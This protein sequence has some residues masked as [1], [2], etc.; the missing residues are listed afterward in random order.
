MKR[1]FKIQAALL[2]LLLVAAAGCQR[3]KIGFEPSNPDSGAQVGYFSFANSAL[4]VDWNGE[5][6]N[7]DATTRAEQNVDNYTVE[8]CK[9]DG[10]E[11]VTSF[12]YGERSQKPYELEFGNYYLN[13][14]SGNSREVPDVAWNDDAAYAAKTETFE[15]TS[16][17]TE[18]SPYTFEGK[19]ITC[20]LQSTKVTVS[21]EY[22]MFSKCRDVEIN[23]TMGESKEAADFT[24]KVGTVTL[25]KNEYTGKMELVRQNT[26]SQRAYLR[27]DDPTGEQTESLT[28]S[29]SA[30]YDANGDG[31]TS[32]L[33]Y[34]HPITDNPKAGE[35]RNVI[36]YIKESDKEHTGSI[37]IETIIETWVYD[38]IVDVD[39][40][41]KSVTLSESSI[42]D[43]NHKDAPRIESAGFNFYGE[44][45]F[46]PN[47]YQNDQFKG[48]AD[49]TVDAVL[50]PKNFVV[51]LSTGNATFGELLTNNNINNA[52]VDMLEGVQT[53]G[54]NE[55][56][57]LA[58]Y[59]F[60]TSGA[61]GTKTTFNVSGYLN[62][63]RSY[64]G[65]HK[66]V[67]EVTN[68]ENHTS[69]VE[70]R[71]EIAGEGSETP[72]PG[73]GGDGNDGGIV[74]TWVGHE[75][76]D[77]YQPITDT[78]T[79]KINIKVPN[80]IEKL[81]GTLG[82][83]LAKVIESDDLMP[84]SFDLCE[85][86][87]YKEDLGEALDGFEIPNGDAVKDKEEVDVDI[88]GFLIIFPKGESEFG[89]EVTDKE[90]NT[91]NATIRLKR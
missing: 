80:K 41:T 7:T 15:I 26:E 82:G 53:R 8:I 31:N 74:I 36:L 89:L 60:P 3:E 55:Q 78:L 4:S 47:D 14:Y 35:W 75:F 33:E 32:I 23:V 71:V 30:Y 50:Q 5:N 12:K 62:A 77:E 2:M 67:I 63:I 16:A 6:I 61:I 83:E 84:L 34:Q 10:D 24:G 44:N 52:P 40:V 39:I 56:T 79:C 29:F 38:E 18:E 37:T 59:G 76:S 42:P 68:V 21:V 46:T 45:R 43:I 88:S 70:L 54:V 57:M 1:F 81:M 49:I 86:D 72:Q 27:P 66:A 91:A 48:N 73:P 17:H 58:G 28:L 64:P 51:T 65:S 25:S 90:G 19:T 20:T 69:R 11:V 22:L 85:P 13:I 9:A 87:K